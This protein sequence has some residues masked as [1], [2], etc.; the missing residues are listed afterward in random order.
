[1]QWTSYTADQPVGEVAFSTGFHLRQ[2]AMGRN[3]ELHV[4]ETQ[5]SYGYDRV[6]AWDK[7]R[8]LSG[9]GSQNPSWYTANQKLP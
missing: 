7:D 8:M 9:K 2:L 4:K 6:S 1:M 3:V 5:E